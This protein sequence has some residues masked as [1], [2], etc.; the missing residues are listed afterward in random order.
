MAAA[1]LRAA[2]TGTPASGSRM[3]AVAERFLFP[4]RPRPVSEGTDGLRASLGHARNATCGNAAKAQVGGT[5]RTAVDDRRQAQGVTCGNVI[6][7]IT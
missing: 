7:G 4:A 6:T 1:G 2:P 5:G 3:G